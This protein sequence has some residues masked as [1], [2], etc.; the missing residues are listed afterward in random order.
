MTM[1]PADIPIVTADCNDESLIDYLFDLNGY[2][3]IKGAVAPEDIAEMNAWGDSHWDYMDKALRG[4]RNENTDGEWIGRVETHSYHDTDGMNF[5]NII[6]AGPVFERHIDHPS[7]IEHVRRWVNPANG[8]SLHETLLNLRG[9]GGYIS[10]HCGGHVPG[11]Y[12]TFRHA[13]TGQWM[14]GQINCITALTDIGPGDGATTLIP[15][16]HKAS[17]P[18]PKLL[19]VDEETYFSEA[20]GDA[21]GMRE[22]YMETG[23]TLLFTD[24]ITHGSATRTNEGYRRMVLYRYSPT[25][26]RSRFNYEPS[27]ELLERLTPEQRQIVQPFPVRRPS[28]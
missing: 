26:I 11:T 28:V 1:P 22:L 5:Q 4:G 10:I 8:L 12:M 19:S 3:I 9:Q 15:G 20:A 14:V 6:E 27:P 23:D 18:H 7:W 2:L 25:F 24:A 16:A 21:V 13:N 17:I